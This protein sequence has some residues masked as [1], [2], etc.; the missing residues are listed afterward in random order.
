MTRKRCSV[1]LSRRSYLPVSLDSET[2]A[3]IHGLIGAANRDRQARTVLAT[4]RA[5]LFGGFREDLRAAFRGAQLHRPR[6]TSERSRP[7]GEMRLL[8]RSGSSSN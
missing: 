8:R 7:C 1:R 6:G 4:E 3:R 5:D 2:V